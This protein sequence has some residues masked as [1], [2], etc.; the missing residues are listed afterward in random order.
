MEER[1]ARIEGIVEQMDKRLNH[2]ESEIVG[3]RGEIGGLRRDI[4][5]DFEGFKRDIR[6]D[7]E[8]LRGEFE[9]FK[10]ED[11]GGFKKDT[12]EDFGGLRRELNE[13]RG[14]VR[15]I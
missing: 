10:K 5:E 12:K 14:D 11:F 13:L 1:I 3:L 4:R 2:I 7:F 15:R 9:T 8:G 6:E